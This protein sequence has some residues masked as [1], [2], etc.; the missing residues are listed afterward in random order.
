MT[1]TLELCPEVEAQLAAQANA[2]GL[3]LKDYLKKIV[4]LQAGARDARSAAQ[5]MS[6]EEW[7]RE[8]EAFI[9]SSPQQPVLPDDAISRETSRLSALT[10]DAHRRLESHSASQTPG[11]AF[12]RPSKHR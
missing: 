7:E 10:S 9:D 12:H 2:C 4:E 1:I 6:Y 11:R 5:T 3:S 8:F